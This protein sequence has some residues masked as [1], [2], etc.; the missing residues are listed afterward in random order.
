MLD[1]FRNGT[2]EHVEVR[3][4]VPRQMVFKAADPMHK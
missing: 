2:I 1:A 3:A 4:G